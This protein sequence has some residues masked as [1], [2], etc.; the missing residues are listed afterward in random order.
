MNVE[1]RHAF[2]NSPSSAA[3]SRSLFFFREGEEED[4]SRLRKLKDEIK[5]S[6]G[7]VKSYTAAASLQDH[8]TASLLKMLNEDFPSGEITER[9]IQNNALRSYEKQKIRSYIGNSL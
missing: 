4:D 1:V 2:L 8:L 9:E 5:E 6:G 3:A 7:N